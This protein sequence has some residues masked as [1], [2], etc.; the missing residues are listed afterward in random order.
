MTLEQARDIIYNVFYAAWGE[1]G[2]VVWDDIPATV[3]STDKPWARV[4]LKHNGGGQSSL[5]G[6]VGT[7]RFNRYG[8]VAVK[9][10]VPV[11]GGQTKAYQLA[12]M[13]SNAYEDARLDVWFRNTRI[14][15]VGASGA[16]EQID[17]LT[18]FLYDEVR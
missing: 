10:F 7:R 18:D 9:I 12:Q 4:V 15:E 3:P 6:E 13:V 16:F 8:I 14:Q 1:I 2:P 5:A 11:G 17:V